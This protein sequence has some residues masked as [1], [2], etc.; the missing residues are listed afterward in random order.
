MLGLETGLELGQT[1][2]TELGRLDFYKPRVTAGSK[3]LKYNPNQGADP[4]PNYNP[5]EELIRSL[6]ITLTRS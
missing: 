6:T 3:E 4:K 5:N 2:M 1:R